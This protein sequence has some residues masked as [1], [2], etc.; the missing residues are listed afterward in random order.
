[1]KV[2]TRNSSGML[3]VQDRPGFEPRR[4]IERSAGGWRSS[5][6]RRPIVLALLAILV[7]SAC[8]EPATTPSPSALA[9]VEPSAS[10]SSPIPSSTSVPSATPR[11]TATPLPTA[12]PSPTPAPTP[13]PWQKYTSKRNR[14]TMKYPPEW[15]VTPGSSKLADQFD[16]Y[17]SPWVFVDRDVLSSGT[18][19]IPLTATHLT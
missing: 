11:P 19:S 3:D 4:H 17:G 14:Y 7:V 15:I 12:T 18:V 2:P 9:A 10:I 5:V 8:G 16:N 1:M 6:I 13:T